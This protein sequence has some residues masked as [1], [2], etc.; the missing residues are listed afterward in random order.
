[1][2]PLMRWQAALSGPH[3]EA[4]RLRLSGHFRET[5]LIDQTLLR[6]FAPLI[7]ESN[8]EG[9]WQRALAALVNLD[10]PLVL[11]AVAG[12]DGGVPHVRVAAI[13]ALPPIESL[14]APE[15][16]STAIDI[17]VGNGAPTYNEGDARGCGLIYWA[18]ALT[19]V[20]APVVRGFAGQARV[21]K[22]LRQAV[23]EVIPLSGANPAALDDFAWRMRRALDATLDL[24]R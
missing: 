3:A 1:M 13:L 16:I 20:S 2:F 5:Y 18:T 12:E 15:Q 23:E 8:E 9:G 4:Q 21:L 6:A 11:D 22:L 19:I 24:L 7:L 10:V 14:S 17:A